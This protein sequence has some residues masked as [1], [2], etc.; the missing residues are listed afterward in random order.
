MDTSVRNL[1]ECRID[2]PMPQRIHMNLDHKRFVTDDMKILVDETAESLA[3]RGGDISAAPA[4]E[5]AGARAKIYFDPS[6]VKVGIVTCGGLCPGINNVIAGLV[7]EMRTLY[8]VKEFRG[9]QYGYQGL[10]GNTPTIDLTTI[11]LQAIR[12]QGGSILG[13]SRGNQDPKLIVDTL[14]KDGISIFFVIG[15]DGTMRGAEA[16]Y[17]EITNRRL[18][19]SVVCIPKT[20][21]NDVPLIDHSFG[22]QTA[23][24]EAARA[25]S[26][27]YVEAT[28]SRGGISLI[29]LM[30]RYSGFIAC[31]AAL[32]ET[33]ADFV[34]IPEVPFA[35]EGKGGFL[36]HLE[37]RMR[38]HDYAVIV[39]AEG[40]GQEHFSEVR[41]LD[42]S[43]N[44]RL[45]D[46]GGLLRE[47]IQ[48]HFKSINYPIS[49]RYI[50]PSYAIRSVEAN[51]YD[52]VYCLQLAQSAVHAAIA[53]KTG[54]VVGQ[55]RRRFVHIPVEL[56]NRETN[57]VNPNGDLWWSVLENTGQPAHFG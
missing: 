21:D 49:L 51:S 4:F 33:S 15:G 13:T 37:E 26:A 43:G 38:E 47:R 29:K 32:A 25:I 1:G 8:G 17:Q 56:L 31:F 55:F 16:I 3:S 36:E 7:D 11:D 42:A 23:F 14:V 39:V 53:G 22:F 30:G 52:S 5:R 46:I 28:A 19:I 57:Q 10:A 45:A 9:Y 18:S 40:A 20:I 41:E 27:G 35:I 24:T 6:N 2:T 44:K 12:G 54:V 48:A 34:L 50:D